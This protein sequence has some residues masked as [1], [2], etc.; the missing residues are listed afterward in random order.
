MEY[1]DITR[2]NA[3]GISVAYYGMA[4]AVVDNRTVVVSKWEADQIGLAVNAPVNIPE[5]VSVPYIQVEYGDHRTVDISVLDKTDLIPVCEEL[6][7]SYDKVAIYAS[8]CNLAVWKDG[9]LIH[10]PVNLD[11]FYIGVSPEMLAMCSL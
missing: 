5:F 8:G 6:S 4:T 2:K 10:G 7:K 9:V 1:P 11:H 3:D